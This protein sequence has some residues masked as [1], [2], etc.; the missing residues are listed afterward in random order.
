MVFLLKPY[1]TYGKGYMIVT[2]LSAGLI[3]P[4]A[5]ITY[6]FLTQRI[7]DVISSGGSFKDA[8]MTIFILYGAN[9]AVWL[10]RTGIRELYLD[11]KKIEIENKI[12]KDIYSKAIATDYIFFDNPDFFDDYTWATN[13]YSNKASEAVDTVSALVTAFT[14]VS[15]LVGIISTAGPIII[16]LSVLQLLATTYIEMKRKSVIIKQKD[17]ML[18]FDR[19]ISYVH[20]TMYSRENIQD[21]KATRV[22]TLL[23]DI[24]ENNII[25]KIG[26]H[27]KH[28]Y[29]IFFTSLGNVLIAFFTEG[30]I[31]VYISYGIIVSKSIE[32]AGM[33]LGLFYAAQNLVSSLQDF[34]EISVNINDLSMYAERIKRFNDFPSKIECSVTNKSANLCNIQPYSVEL[35]NMSFRYSKSNFSLRDI[36]IKIRPGEKIAIVG[37]NGAGKSTLVK[38]LLRLYDTD[39]GDIFYNNKHIKDYDVYQLR[40]C[41]GVAFQTPQVYAMSLADNI[42]IYRNI[43]ENQLQEVIRNVGLSRIIKKSNANLYTE[44]TREFDDRGIVLSGGEMQKLSIARLMAASYGEGFGLIVLDEPSSALDPL[45][46][47][48][49]TNLIFDRANTSTTIIISHRLSTVRDADRIYVIDNGSILEEGKHE[50]LMKNKSKYYEMFTKQAENY[51]RN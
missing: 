51:V 20:R 26:A 43:E 42:Q 14:T 49:L 19:K 34:F 11:S 13:E 10:I 47:Y 15:A 7:V 29:S 23:S 22:K 36:N 39:S 6:V 16:L 48:E 21:I 37:E 30:L 45:A 25:L 27:K 4:L 38:L 17:A 8:F 2:F 9:M 33:F 24:L 46:E 18:P 44:I 35:R 32:G 12:K 41:I 50:E 1:W 40:Q 28:I 5:P 31:M 3:A